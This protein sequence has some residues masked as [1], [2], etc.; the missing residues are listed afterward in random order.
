[1]GIYNVEICTE[2]TQFLFWEDLFGVF[3]IV[4]LAAVQSVLVNIASRKVNVTEQLLLNVAAHN[5][6]VTKRKSY[7]T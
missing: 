7:K 5:V 2:A 1:V 4:S 6:E 3:S